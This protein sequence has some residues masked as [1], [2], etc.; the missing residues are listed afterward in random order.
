MAASSDAAGST[1]LVP[2]A[3]GENFPFEELCKCFEQLCKPAG[4][5]FVRENIV[6]RLWS[7]YDT[8]SNP[9]FPLIRLML[10]HLDTSSRPNYKL[11]QKK[12]A[13]LYVD[14]M[15]MDKNST[16]ARTITEW[17]RPSSGLQRSEQGNFP[18]VMYSVLKN[19]CKP[20]AELRRVTVGEVNAM[21]DHLATE[22][23]KRP[24]MLNIHNRCTALEP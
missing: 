5:R 6:K 12:L 18:E 23:E 1:A 14:I 10:P 17:K 22:D 20:R 16:D 7:N 8:A 2:V 3:R 11:K 4:D 15:G 13:D 9:T 19:R 24:P 21:L